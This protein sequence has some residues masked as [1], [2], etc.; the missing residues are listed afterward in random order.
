LKGIKG[1]EGLIINGGFEDI[2]PAAIATGR[3]LGWSTASGSVVW[4]SDCNDTTTPRTGTRAV[5]LEF[6]AA[7]NGHLYTLSKSGEDDENKISIDTDSNYYFKGYFKGR[8]AG[9]VV[10]VTAIQYTKGGTF[11]KNTT[12]LNIGMSTS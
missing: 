8:A 12:L 9:D 1:G 4:H 10:V 2:D 11:I 5:Y 7:N 3:P 6:G